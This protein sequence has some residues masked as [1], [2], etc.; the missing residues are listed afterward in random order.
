M[1]AIGLL[2][3]SSLNFWIID[4]VTLTDYFRKA[5]NLINAA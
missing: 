2:A 3:T 4:Y 5:F 1:S